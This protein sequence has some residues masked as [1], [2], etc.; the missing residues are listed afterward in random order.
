MKLR[1]AFLAALLLSVAASSSA[2]ANLIT[3]TLSLNGSGL[4]LVGGSTILTASQINASSTSSTTP[5]S[6]DFVAVPPG[7]PFDALN[8][9]ISTLASGGGVSLSNASFGTF[10]AV[11]GAELSSSHT[12]QSGVDSYGLVLQVTGTF[13]PQG[14][15]SGYSPNDGTVLTIAL[16]QTVVTGVGTS[17]SESLTLGAPTVVPE[18][19]TSVLAGLGLVGLCLFSRFRKWRSK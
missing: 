14:T 10:T 9:N 15:L 16:T 6:G 1:Y 5:V 12:S 3:G 8:I 7:T 11:G 18:P 17:F 13:V 19:S 2:Q 4:S